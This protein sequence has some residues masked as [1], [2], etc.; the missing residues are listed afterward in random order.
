MIQP[1]NRREVPPAVLDQ[2][3][4]PAV[5]GWPELFDAHTTHVRLLQQL[6][7]ENAEQRRIT[8][9][10]EAED[11]ARAAA[12]KL[13]ATAGT[14]PELPAVTSPEEREAELA[15][16]G[17]RRKAVWEALLDHIDATVAVVA[18][19]ADEWT[20]TL[21]EAETAV[22]AEIA[23]AREALREAESRRGATLRYREW[24]DRT[25]RRAAEVPFLHMQFSAIPAP[26]PGKHDF[27][28]DAE[29]QAWVDKQTERAYTTDAGREAIDRE[30]A[31]AHA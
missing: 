6:D 13:A 7:A 5:P 11:E 8:E 9:R 30:E 10:H 12:L 20:A 18:D 22:D 15:E 21:D 23:A 28:R 24:I 19:H 16:V 1:I 27:A 25:G 2:G 26:P 4:T 29:R 3:W 14:E 31:E 17:E